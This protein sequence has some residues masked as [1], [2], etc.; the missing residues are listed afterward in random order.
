MNL[1][2][3]MVFKM[4]TFLLLF[5]NYFTSRCIFTISN[6]L[7]FVCPAYFLSS[8]MILCDAK[9]SNTIFL[10]MLHL[11]TVYL[12]CML[13]FLISY[14]YCMCETCSSIK[15]IFYLDILYSLIQYYYILFYLQFI[16]Y[17]PK[18]LL[19]AVCNCRFI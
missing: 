6:K 11:Q 17:V 5:K 8:C 19:T 2:S 18:M 14:L 1:I 3:D 7:H 4:E 9:I 16:N 15:L 10:I 13:A 12:R